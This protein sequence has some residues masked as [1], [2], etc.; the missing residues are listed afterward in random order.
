MKQ[1]IIL[2]G[3]AMVAPLEQGDLDGLCGLY[4]AINAVAVVLAPVRPLSSADI[5]I[6][7]V[8]GIKHLSRRGQLADAIRSGMGFGTQYRLTK[9]LAKK[10]ARLTSLP[11]AV[12]RPAKRH[13]PLRRRDL[14]RLLEQGMTDG[15]AMIVRFENALDHYSVVVGRSQTRFYLHDSGGR[16]WIAR[17]A[18]GT[19]R[20]SAR[21]HHL[22]AKG[23][24]Q[25]QIMPRS[26]DAG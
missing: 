9:A 19:R 26:T 12:T 23:L 16:C 4:A 5:D 24:V 3:V 7:F 8:A 25:V 2:E 14:L 17:A 6:L 13:T 21:R 20:C 11:I 22:R 1:R 18:L 15:A 10:A